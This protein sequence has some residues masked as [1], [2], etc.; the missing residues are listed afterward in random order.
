MLTLSHWYNI[1][2]VNVN[3]FKSYSTDGTNGRLSEINVYWYL[4]Q[5]ELDLLNA[6]IGKQ[7]KLSSDSYILI[8]PYAP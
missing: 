8:S 3:F 5:P 6:H 2:Y 7:R 1:N 4:L